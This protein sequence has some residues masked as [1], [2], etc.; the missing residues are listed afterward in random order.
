VH[1]MTYMNNAGPYTIFILT[2]TISG[3]SH[4]VCSIAKDGKFQVGLYYRVYRISMQR[5]NLRTYQ[6]IP[7]EDASKLNGFCIHTTQAYLQGAVL[8]LPT[9]YLSDK[10]QH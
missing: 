3:H 2:Y 10:K 7:W 5:F 6:N 9:D 1:S 4:A 8:R